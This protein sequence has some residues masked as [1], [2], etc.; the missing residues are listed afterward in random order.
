MIT[1]SWNNT[2]MGLA[3]KWQASSAVNRRCNRV[4]IALGPFNVEN[5]MLEF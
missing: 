4:L 3:V 1:T 5:G 2:T